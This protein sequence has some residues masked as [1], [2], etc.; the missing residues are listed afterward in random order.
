MEYLA[1]LAGSSHHK[2]LASATRGYQM[3][4]LRPQTDP[5]KIADDDYPY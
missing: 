5:K 2:E 4:Q 1:S 3:N